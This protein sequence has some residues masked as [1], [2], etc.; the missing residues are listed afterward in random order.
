M[1]EIHW[2]ISFFT[3]DTTCRSLEN[4]ILCLSCIHIFTCIQ[5]PNR[6]QRNGNGKWSGLRNIAPTVKRFCSDLTA[7]K[8]MFAILTV[9]IILFIMRGY[10]TR[11]LRGESTNQKH[12]S[13][14]YSPTAKPY[15]NFSISYPE[16]LGL[17][18]EAEEL[19]VREW[20]FFWLFGA[21]FRRM[22]RLE[23]VHHDQRKRFT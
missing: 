15:K 11:R 16:L 18:D 14:E 3:V 23:N 19:W 6:W 21:D 7:L 22:R 17:R 1:T 10:L 12:L 20:N 4:K 5:M 8:L 13:D 2:P 9:F